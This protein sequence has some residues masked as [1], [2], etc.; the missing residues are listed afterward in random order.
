MV[1]E[2]P[3]G[4]FTRQLFLGDTLDAQKIQAT[5]DSG[6]LTLV[7]PVAEQAKPRKIQIS[8]AGA[9]AQAIEASGGSSS[10]TTEK[11]DGAKRRRPPAR[12]QIAR[13]KQSSSR[14]AP[15]LGQDGR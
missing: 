11:D 1:S 6:V 14:R 5:Y 4:E 3:Q 12:R 10:H 7:I 15:T 8:N 9:S 13:N 2:R